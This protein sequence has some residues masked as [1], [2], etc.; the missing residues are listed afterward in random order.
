M[1][2]NFAPLA[3][4]PD[5]LTMETNELCNCQHPVIIL[6]PNIKDIIAVH[7]NYT[8]L[9]KYHDIT[10]SR[11]YPHFRSIFTPG[12][13]VNIDDIDKCFVV[14]KETGEVFP[15]YF[16]VPCGYCAIC[17]S[18]KISAFAHRCLLETQMYPYAPWFISLTYSNK[19]L[20]KTGVQVDHVQRFFKRLRSRFDYYGI[21]LKIRYVAVSEYGYNTHR[22]HYHL[23]IWNLPNWKFWKVARVMRKSW[24]Y[25]H[26]Y[27]SQVSSTY[28]VKGTR[29]GLSK[30]EKCFEYVAKYMCKDGIV[31]P[32]CNK[33]FMLTS[34]GHGGIGAPFLDR[35]KHY[36]RS[37]QRYS[38][39]FIDK[40]SQ[41]KRSLVYSKYVVNRLFPSL[42]QSID[43][44]FR[45]A[46]LFVTRYGHVV[47]HGDKLL[48]RIRPVFRRRLLWC[49]VFPVDWHRFVH[50]KAS[51]PSWF[52]CR[53]CPLIVR[54]YWNHFARV[55]L[56]YLTFDFDQAFDLDRKRKYVHSKLM[57]H[58]KIRYLEP[59][60]RLYY[61]NRHFAFQ[62]E[63]L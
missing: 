18:Q 55:C 19:N 57:E 44:K 22:A 61:K 25:G 45:K 3:V 26:V 60:A 51:R 5:K 31:P 38:F 2:C 47:P 10:G 33:T 4:L 53:S 17:K 8:Y 36:I 54:V 23:L 41:K 16:L 6:N 50:N 32:G 7:K 9:G 29:H 49:E 28:I 59:Q 39:E 62:R 42:C 11:L 1:E 35:H 21:D 52:R 27:C 20:P 63:L 37:H 24:C 48:D 12:S 40:F 15:M 56:D 30:P 43:V 58:K 34:R 14:D 13:R 46:I